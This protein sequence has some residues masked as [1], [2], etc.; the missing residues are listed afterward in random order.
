[1]GIQEEPPGL[2][3]STC[4]LS[5]LSH[6]SI[7]LVATNG[8]PE[9]SGPSRSEGE[10]HRGRRE[11]SAAEQTYPVFPRRKEDWF[12]HHSRILHHLLTKLWCPSLSLEL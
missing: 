2:I 11:S 1:M 5:T 12:N 8:P 9:L 3:T 6:T 10:G 4:S 7:T